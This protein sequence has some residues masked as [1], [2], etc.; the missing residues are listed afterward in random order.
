MK[1]EVGEGRVKLNP[2]APQP[3]PPEKA[4][5]KKPSLIRVKP[6]SSYL[7]NEILFYCYFLLFLCVIIK[8]VKYT[9]IVIFI[10]LWS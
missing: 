6:F 2:P 5:L 8:M 3:H 9:I 10:S 1:W 7:N 4:T